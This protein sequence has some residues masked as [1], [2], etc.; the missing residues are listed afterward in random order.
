MTSCGLPVRKLAAL[1]VVAEAAHPLGADLGLPHR[2]LVDRRPRLSIGEEAARRGKL[3]VRSSDGRLLRVLHA[4]GLRHR[5]RLWGGSTEGCLNARRARRVRMDRALE[6]NA[7]TLSWRPHAAALQ[8]G[9]GRSSIEIQRR[10]RV[11]T[12]PRRCHVCPAHLQKY[13]VQ[14]AR[15]G[16]CSPTSFGRQSRLRRPSAISVRR[17]GKRKGIIP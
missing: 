14:L 5:W 9:R 4:H 17:P 3:S 13:P 1:A 2:L 10:H 12:V 11:S 7:L 8:Y 15:R 6:A 16:L